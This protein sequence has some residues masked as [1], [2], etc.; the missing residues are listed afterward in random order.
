MLVPTPNKQSRLSYTL[1]Q[2]TFI[3]DEAYHLVNH[4]RGTARKYGLS[5]NMIRRWHKIARLNANNQHL[6]SSTR[7]R[8]HGGG[9]KPFIPKELEDA[10]VT[11]VKEKRARDEKVSV[12]MLIIEWKRRDP[13][14]VAGVKRESLRLRVNRIIKRNNIG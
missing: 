3:V 9:R 11:F 10:L 6:L 5:P 13:V 14:S 8:L 4:L 1:A 7:K 2:K 12:C